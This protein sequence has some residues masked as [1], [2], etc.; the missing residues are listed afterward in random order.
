MKTL[1][2]NLM[3]ALFILFAIALL[4]TTISGNISQQQKLSLSDVV[5]KINSGEVAEIIVR[6]SNLEIK[7]RDNSVMESKKE[8]EAPLSETLRNYGVSDEQL[9]AVTITVKDPSGFAYWAGAILPFL[10]PLLLIAAFFW[11][12]AR[13]AQRAN[14]QAFSFGQSRARV[15]H[16]DNKKER[17]LF[18]DVAGAKEAKEEL[19]EIVDFLK[20][21]QKFLNLGARIPRGVL[22][23]GPPGTGK[24]MMAKAVAGEASVP[25][26]HLSASE[27]VEMF[28][29]V[30]ASR[31]RDLF[32]MAKK[33]AP[34]IIF[35]DEIDAVG[36][37]R[38]AGLGGG[39]DEREQTLNQILVELDGFESSDSVIVMAATNRPDVLDPALLRPGRF[40]RRVILDL[41]DINEREEI[42]QIH[43]K[44]KPLAKETNLRHVA[45]RTPGFSGADLFNLV[46]E[47]AI[48]AARQNKTQISQ[49]HILNSIEKVLLGP[50]RKSA[51]LSPL[52]KKITA[53]H[54]AGHALVA[55]LL[56]N[57]DP[58]HKIS[59]IARGRA[60]GFTLK[61]PTED[62]HLYS[63]GHFL[64]DLAVSLGGYAAELT[65]FGELT[66]G[67]SDD[68]RK[69]TDLARALVTK[70]GMSDKIGPLSLA[71]KED[72]IFLGREVAIDKHHSENL[73]SAVDSEVTRFMKNALKTAKSV[74]A[75]HRK[76]L[77]ALAE[78]LIK[79]E[80]VE[81]EQFA[82]FIKSF[83]LAKA[84]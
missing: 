15:I 14:F 40:D 3:G 21:P 73:A 4:Y 72:H 35:I 81:R 47:A 63:K 51:V 10:L 57:T 50:E 60:G 61:L 42:L 39:H 30:G 26:F 38:G 49:T 6:E 75:K 29:G 18:K 44:A 65:A 62:R 17:V 33:A 83:G 22:L 56:P 1:S 2:K 32:K 74:L 66:T 67:A 9:R 36:R 37:H 68:L 84:V 46:N 55:A 48:L 28:V 59:I 58:V 7:L 70:Y 71:S 25:F 77:D 54:E 41:P 69:A 19:V 23:M 80:T 76:A 43:S 31:V 34:S 79:D 13:Q 24:T 53:Y 45:E 5:A 27:F 20:S 16:P 11:I 78:K 12:M 82:Q 8:S 64:S 52:E